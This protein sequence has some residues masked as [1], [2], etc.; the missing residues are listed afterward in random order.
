[1]P[2][3]VSTLQTPSLQTENAHVLLQPNT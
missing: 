2:L 1:L 3:D